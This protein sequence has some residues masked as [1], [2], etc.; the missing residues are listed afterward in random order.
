VRC[1][2]GPQGACT[3]TNEYAVPNSGLLGPTTE[4]PN[5]QRGPNEPTRRDVIL[6]PV[7]LRSNL[8]ALVMESIKLRSAAR[9]TAK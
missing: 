8:P 2:D 6:D 7:E 3:P 9:V 5:D 1:Q 4:D